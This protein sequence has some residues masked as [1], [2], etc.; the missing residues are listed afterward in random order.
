M[1]FTPIQERL[2]QALELAKTVTKMTRDA[3]AG[4]SGGRSTANSGGSVRAPRGHP[5]PSR[6]PGRPTVLPVC[7]ARRVARRP[8]RAPDRRAGPLEVLRRRPG[9]TSASRSGTPTRRRS[10]PPAAAPEGYPERD[11]P[12]R[13]QG[14]QEGGRNRPVADRLAGQEVDPSA[15]RTKH[16]REATQTCTP[17]GGLRRKGDDRDL[18]RGE[19]LSRCEESEESPGSGG[20]FFAFFALSS[21]SLPAS[22]FCSQTFIFRHLLPPSYFLRFFAVVVERETSKSGI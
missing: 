21:A 4:K 8:G 2:G 22:K 12:R 18:A 20:T 1:N 16:R 9:H 11:H 10:W 3:R 6:A 17:G 19:F 7:L 15:G 5:Q 13:L 14:A